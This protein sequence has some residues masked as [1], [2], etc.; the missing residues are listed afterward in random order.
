M[1]ILRTILDASKYSERLSIR[2]ISSQST[3]VKEAMAWSVKVY[4]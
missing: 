1:L 3:S 4:A 2:S